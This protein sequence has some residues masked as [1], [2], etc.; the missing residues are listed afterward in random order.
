MLIV[1]FFMYEILKNNFEFCF[2]FSYNIFWENQAGYLYFSSLPVPTSLITGIAT[3]HQL[4]PSFILPHITS[5]S[6][7]TPSSI[8]PRLIALSQAPTPEG[9]PSNPR[10]APPK[11]TSG[12]RA[13]LHLSYESQSQKSPPQLYSRKAPL[14][15]SSLS[16][17]MSSGSQRSF[18]PNC[19]P[20]IHT[21][22]S[23]SNISDV[24]CEHNQ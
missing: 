24:T 7:K 8:L 21:S 13:D 23:V 2:S 18:S 5:G 15:L 17:S 20:P 3:K 19:L 16:D 12:S 6:P 11:A 4:K 10:A 22:Y 14:G 9:T 1:F